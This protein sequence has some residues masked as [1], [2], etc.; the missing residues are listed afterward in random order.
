MASILPNSIFIHIPKTGGTWVTSALNRA[1]LHKQPMQHLAIFKRLVINKHDSIHKLLELRPKLK[2]LKTF[3]F[4]RNP[5]TW[6][7]S[8]WSCNYN[9]FFFMNPHEHPNPGVKL[10][11]IAI[12]TK[13]E[14]DD[15][16]VYIS[17]V[18]KQQPRC[19]VR[20][21]KRYLGEDYGW[22][23]YVGKF[24]NL[25][26]D[27]VTALTMFGEEFDPEVIRATKAIN[28][29]DDKLDRRWDEKLLQKVIYTHSDFMSRFG[30][31]TNITYYR[32]HIE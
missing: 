30:Y 11:V 6:Y 2:G 17:R 4:V 3:A 9:R 22:L 15:F 5:V 13:K 32:K 16:N 26:E 7:Q 27:L 23:D 28:E 19:F 20:Q 10:P 1:G 18:L 24:E 12:K 25:Q 8:R 14:Y 31:P 29:S 21:M